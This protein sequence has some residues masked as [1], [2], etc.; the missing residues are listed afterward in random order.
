MIVANRMLGLFDDS[1]SKNLS[2]FSQRTISDIT[3]MGCSKPAHVPIS[4][5]RH[6]GIIKPLVGKSGPMLPDRISG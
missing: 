3:R 2:V 1:L 4:E 5:E 6:F